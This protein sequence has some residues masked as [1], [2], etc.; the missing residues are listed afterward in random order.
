MLFDQQQQT[1]IVIAFKF[2]DTKL[3]YIDQRLRYPVQIHCQP[4]SEQKSPL[5]ND[6]HK[7]EMNGTSNNY[8]W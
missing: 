7:I 3:D 4:S 6:I 8:V 5:T 1:L 2:M